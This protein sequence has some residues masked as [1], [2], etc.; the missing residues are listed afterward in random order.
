LGEALTLLRGWLV[1][2]VTHN[3]T[4]LAAGGALGTYARYAVSTWVGAPPWARGFPVGTFLINVSGSFILGAA[5][6]VIRERLPP[7]Y[8]YLSLLVGTG[9]C[10]GYTTFSTFE[11]ETLRLMSDGSWWLALAYVV[12][13][14]GAGLLGALVAVA[15]VHAVFPKG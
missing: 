6:V 10:G 9:F 11:H 14:V 12:G 2:L 4:L 5:T 7:A 1:G 15:L 3:V 13:S 8:S